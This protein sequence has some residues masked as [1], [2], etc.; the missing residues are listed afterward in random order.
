MKEKLRFLG[1]DVHAET[2]RSVHA[3]RSA[4][5]TCSTD[6]A[7]VSDPAWLLKMGGH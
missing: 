2:L 6:A 3:D 1:L 5:G 7:L 4:E